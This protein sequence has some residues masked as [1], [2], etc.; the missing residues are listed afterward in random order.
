MKKKLK[1]VIKKLRPSSSSQSKK[2]TN[3]TFDFQKIAQKIAN[4]ERLSKEEAIQWLTVLEK[5]VEN[6]A[7]MAGVRTNMLPKLYDIHNRLIV[8][9]ISS[10]DTKY[11][12]LLKPFASIIDQQFCNKVKHQWQNAIEQG[13]PLAEKYS[14]L[15]QSAKKIIKS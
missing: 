7:R 6:K 8:V 10:D 3:K 13:I 12:E 1:E 2:S 4:Q 14:K 15:L 9:M 11:D 5:H